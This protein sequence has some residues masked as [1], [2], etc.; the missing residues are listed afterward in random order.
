MIQ[1]VSVL[2]SREPLVH[3]IHLN[4]QQCNK[5][6]TIDM[7]YNY[8]QYLVYKY[9]HCEMKGQFFDSC[10]Y[11]KLFQGDQPTILFWNTPTGSCTSCSGHLTVGVFVSET[12]TRVTEL[13]LLF[14]LVSWG[15]ASASGDIEGKLYFD[16]IPGCK[17]SGGLFFSSK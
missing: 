10:N 1:S 2:L 12:W 15:V 14:S 5:T 9:K 6:F 17:K 4:K 7:W 8:V 3:D 11:L 13:T 16:S